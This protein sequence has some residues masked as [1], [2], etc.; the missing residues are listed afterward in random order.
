VADE[1]AAVRQRREASGW[2]GESVDRA[3]AALRIAA[4]YALSR[5]PAQREVVSR[6]RRIEGAIVHG[7]TRGRHIVVSAAVTPESV[8]RERTLASSDDRGADA[9]R[10]ERLESLHE[11]LARFT[12][13]SYAARPS[14]DSD[15]LDRA[16][17]VATR[18]VETERRGR[19]RLAR[20]AA[21]VS[22]RVRD[23]LPSWSR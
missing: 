8:R 10:L 19:G 22:G 18:L 5:L 12:S 14:L 16:L 9:R 1:L 3:L 17:A 11:A 7:A 20:G 15:A 6:P 4:S 2:T 21:A 13:A 23:F